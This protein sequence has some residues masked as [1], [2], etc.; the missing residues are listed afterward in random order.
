MENETPVMEQ[1][2]Q[3]QAEPQAQEQAGKLFTQEDVNRILTERLKR[4]R[5]KFV[6][7]ANTGAQQK[8][9]ELNEREKTLTAREMRLNCREYV[10]EKGY[11]EELLDT[12]DT[13]DFE[14]FK[15]KADGVCA[16]LG[17]QQPSRIVE[18]SRSHEP[19]RRRSDARHDGE[20]SE[21]FANKPHTP[22]GR[23]YDYE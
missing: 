9:T 13:S 22:K 21:A 7:E 18:P 11:P 1:E 23:Y 2:T 4:E 20:F 6:R 16:A 3:K 12:L 15:K 14:T 5:E 10:K 8:E 17:W 19:A